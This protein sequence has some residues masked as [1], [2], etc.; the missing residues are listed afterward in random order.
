MTVFT[1]D[2]RVVYFLLSSGVCYLINTLANTKFLEE[3]GKL[4]AELVIVFPGTGQSMV[5]QLKSTINKPVE[6]CFPSQP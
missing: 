3:S 1:L 5:W 4:G 6:K 2:D